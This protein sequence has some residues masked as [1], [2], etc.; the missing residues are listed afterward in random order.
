MAARATPALVSCLREAGELLR[1]V[2]DA[3]DRMLISRRI[4]DA[5]YRL[6]G[7]RLAEA[8]ARPAPPGRAAGPGR[9][10]SSGSCRS[11][12]CCTT[13]RRS[14]RSR[15][16]RRRTLAVEPSCRRSVGSRARAVPIES[17]GA[18][19]RARGQLPTYDRLRRERAAQPPSLEALVGRALAADDAAASR[20]EARS[21]S[22]SARSA[23]AGGP[24]LERAAAV[25]QQLADELARNGGLEAIQPLLQELLD[26]VPLALAES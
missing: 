23:I 16:A 17:L 26:L 13:R 6:D 18:V 10:P 4:L 9:A 2:A 1:A 25:R 15:A 21:P 19:R 7:L 11:S 8:D 20:R 3:D 14:S 12:R 5:A 24:A 22:R